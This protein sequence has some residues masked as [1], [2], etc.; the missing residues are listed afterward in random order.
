MA[1]VAQDIAPRLTRAAVTR[2]PLDG[3]GLGLYGAIQSMASPLGVELTPVNI[4]NRT[5]MERTI[6]ALSSANSGLVI[7]G[8][9]FAIFHRDLIVTLAARY[10][11]P[12]SLLESRARRRRR[13][14]VLRT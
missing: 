10:K 11:V 12:R 9:A 4:R 7:P 13:L 2:D 8:S 3:A 1:A 14:D 6:A 5:E